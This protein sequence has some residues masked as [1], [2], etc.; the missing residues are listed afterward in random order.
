M[1]QPALEFWP[2]NKTRHYIQPETAW[3]L[4]D[5]TVTITPVGT[6]YYVSD[7]YSL[8]NSDK[9]FDYFLKKSWYHV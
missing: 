2:I 4:Y 7:I 1:T 6:F 3:L 5:I 8:Q 9:T